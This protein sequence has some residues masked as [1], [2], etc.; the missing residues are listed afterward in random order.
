M[1]A[2]PSAWAPFSSIP[3][4]ALAVA[5][6]FLGDQDL[7]VAASVSHSFQEQLPAACEEQC[8]SRR[9]IPE[10]LP[11]GVGFREFL[12]GQFPDAM[13]A[14]VFEE[15]FGSID[16]VPAVPKKFTDMAPQPGFKLAFIPEYITIT[17]DADSTLRLDETTAVDGKK[18]RLTE[19]PEMAPQGQRRT[20]KVP[21]TLKNIVL[22]AQKHLK[23]YRGISQFAGIDENSWANVLDQNGD[24]GVGPSHWSYQKK[25]V[26]GLGKFYDS[27]VEMANDAG[28]EITPLAERVIFDLLSYIKSGEIPQSDYF[29]RT[30]TIVRDSTGISRQ[31]TIWWRASGPVFRLYLRNYYDFYYVGAVAR[32][33]AESSQA[34]GHS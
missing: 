5:L 17:V 18:A 3:N 9:F 2:I 26:I 12:F 25:S 8:K 22:L 34:I 13:G 32:V 21:I 15:Y 23:K 29:E 10:A 1:S 28:L 27:Q 16:T 14:D 31:S 24:V 11:P 33:S 19:N 30:S 6:S 7:R 20:I 4:D